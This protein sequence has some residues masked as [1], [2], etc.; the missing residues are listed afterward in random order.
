MRSESR[1][2]LRNPLIQQWP[3]WEGNGCSRQIVQVRVLMTMA[4]VIS[5]CHLTDHLL[6]TML[7]ILMHGFYLSVTI[8][9]SFV[10]IFHTRNSSLGGI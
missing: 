6:S 9:H 2:A 4:T 7:S 10:F 3:S 5:T 8:T 1:C